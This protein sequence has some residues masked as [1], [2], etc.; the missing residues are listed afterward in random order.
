MT[1][2]ENHIV[3]VGAHRT[4]SVII[5]ALE[6][7]KA[8]FVVVDFNPMIVKRLKERDIQV[9]YGDVI[10]L[11]IQ[12][13]AGLRNARLVI[14]TVPDIFD[15]AILLRTAKAMNSDTQ[16][17]VTA[18][19]DW[20]GLELYKE[21]ADYVLLPHFLGGRQLATIIKEDRDFENLHEYKL[22]DMEMIRQDI[23]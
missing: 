23:V 12:E 13:R 14:S 10:D 11:E 1:G 16:V 8:D 20:E 4:G 21:G 22:R 2:L 5:N 15:A 3:L 18:Q 9:I 17:I 19:S 6:E 7:V